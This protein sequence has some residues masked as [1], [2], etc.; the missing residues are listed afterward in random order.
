MG[1]NHEALPHYLMALKLNSKTSVH[2]S[3]GLL[4]SKMGRTDESEAHYK[5]KAL[6][7][8]PNHIDAHNNLGILL[9][10]TGR[11][12]EGIAHCRR[13]LEAS[14]RA[15]RVLKNLGVALGQRGQLWTCAGTT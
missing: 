11:L 8:D 3:I 10:S 6:E 5:K 4:F 13:A 7:I 9:A 14:P 15:V 12:D 1:R 2:Y